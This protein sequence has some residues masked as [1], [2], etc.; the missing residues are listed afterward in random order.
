LTAEPFDETTIAAHDG[1]G[2]LEEIWSALNPDFR[3]AA[4]VLDPGQGPAG[5][6]LRLA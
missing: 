3:I 1:T 2:L 6:V 5:A 4:A